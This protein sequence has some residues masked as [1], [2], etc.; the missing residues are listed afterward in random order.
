MHQN[1]IKEYH[2]AVSTVRE[3]KSNIN[4]ITILKHDGSTTQTVTKQ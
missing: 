4:N 1:S 2:L 3:H